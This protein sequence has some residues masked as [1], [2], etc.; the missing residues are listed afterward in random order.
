MRK[1]FFIFLFLIAGR[2]LAFSPAFVNFATNLQAKT[3]LDGQPFEDKELAQCWDRFDTE[4]LRAL[5]NTEDRT[6]EPLNKKFAWKQLEK[7]EKRGTEIE[8]IELGAIEAKFYPMNNT[9]ESWLVTYYFGYGVTPAST[10]RI[11]KK[12]GGQF[13]RAYSFEKDTTV[14]DRAKLQWSTLQIQTLTDTKGARQFNSFHM[15]KQGGSKMNRNQI[16]WEWNGGS[17]VPLRRRL[18]DWH[19]EKGKLLP[20]PS[21]YVK[22]R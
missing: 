18:A 2:A 14:P 16:D 21:R 22:V 1:L 12:E 17:L 10:F 9:P 20:G 5:N 13:T 8:S 15:A 7:I 19:E 6:E 4:I 3:L 11:F